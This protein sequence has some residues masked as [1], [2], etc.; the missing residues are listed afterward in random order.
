MHAE[1][2]K[3][4]FSTACARTVDN[5]SSPTTDGPLDCDIRLL[6]GADWDGRRDT[7][8]KEALT[9]GAEI[10]ARAYKGPPQPLQDLLA[11]ILTQHLTMEIER[12]FLVVGTSWRTLS[13]GSTSIQQG[14]L[15]SN[16]TA[17]VRIRIR[18]KK[19][20]IVTV[21]S[22]RS[23]IAREEFEYDVPIEDGRALL[24]LCGDRTLSKRRYRVVVGKDEWEVD[25]FRGR[26]EGLVMAELE[27]KRRNQ[28]IDLPDWIGK[29]VT[30]DQRYRNGALAEHG[31][32]PAEAD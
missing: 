30:Q 10:L 23:G 27:L 17:G 6:Q 22:A 14:Y 24:R 21:K 4:D 1:L 19:R 13:R 29:E 28:K 3:A 16:E 31:L 12:K 2:G 8:E 25:E 20:A 15:A 5:R 18:D 9:L 26:H 32:P 7:I 11:P